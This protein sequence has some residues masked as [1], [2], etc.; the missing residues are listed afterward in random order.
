M[1]MISQVFRCPRCVFFGK[2]YLNKCIHGI[3]WSFSGIHLILVV[4]FQKK[5]LS[6][7]KNPGCLVYIGDYTT[8]LY[9]D[10]NKPL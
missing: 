8:Q 6:N 7:E 2:R 10:F 5:Q 3:F 4:E 1:M 9:R